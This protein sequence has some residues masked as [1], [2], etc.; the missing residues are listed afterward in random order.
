MREE[1]EEKGRRAEVH[2]GDL[3]SH[4]CRKKHGLPFFGAKTNDFIHLFLKVFI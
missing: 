3:I 1:N 4:G 2:V